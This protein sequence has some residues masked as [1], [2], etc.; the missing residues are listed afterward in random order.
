M[1]TKELENTKKELYEIKRDNYNK[2]RNY[3]EK[4]K[5]CKVN[6]KDSQLG[7]TLAISTFPY[8]ITIFILMFIDGKVNMNL[9]LNIIP[10][11]VV[12]IILIGGSLGIGS[13]INKLINKKYKT[14]ERFN[15]FS[16]SKTEV[17]KIKDEVLNQI[18]LEKLN[19]RNKV[20]D[21]IIKKIEENI[22]I[23]SRISSRYRVTYRSLSQT[24]EETT[25]YI[26]QISNLLEEKYQ[27]LDV[28]TTKKV[29][30]ENFW[31]VRNKI[32][33]GMEL[34]M[35][36]FGAGIGT[37]MLTTLPFIIT[38]NLIGTITLLQTNIIFISSLLGGAIVPEIYW[39]N[40]TKN[41]KNA[42]EEL[43]QTLEQNSLP[44][45]IEDA[46]REEVELKSLIERKISEISL[47]EVQ[48]L[49]QKQVLERLTMDDSNDKQ[50]EFIHSS[51]LSNVIY[52]QE[53]N[54]IDNGIN[55]LNS[56]AKQKAKEPKKLVRKPQS[57]K[58]DNN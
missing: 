16:K 19:N 7:N 10:P 31:K 14:K 20:I 8:F 51:T 28:L 37:M 4:M 27:E 38:N 23:L 3:N 18:E 29:L 21:D 35:V 33:K 56:I 30:H 54:E 9:P 34:I 48:L 26:N 13:V 41:R 53:Q 24:K 57:N 40:R 52:E 12:P 43:N 15:S 58:Q 5:M 1:T 47:A 55:T 11:Y 45:N 6:Q 32:Q 39:I 17:E 22:S 50:K 46:K 42:F 2:I 25:D 44:N 49:E 36:A